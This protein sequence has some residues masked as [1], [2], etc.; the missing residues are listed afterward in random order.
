[1]GSAISGVPSEEP[2]STKINSA[3]GAIA[4]IR[5]MAL[6]TVEDS[7]KAGITTDR[8]VKENTKKGFE[9]LQM[10]EGV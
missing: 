7:F 9:I 10:A 8:E 2:P 5:L 6:S 1:M 3:E 4:L